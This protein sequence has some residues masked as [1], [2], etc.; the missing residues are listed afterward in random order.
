MNHIQTQSFEIIRS[1]FSKDE[2][3][4][5]REEADHVSRVEGSACVRHLR[6]KS[7]EFDLLAISGRLLD[8]LPEGLSPVRSILFDKTPE[9]NW[10][11]PWHQD[12]TITVEEKVEVAG[13]EP[14]STKDGS[15]HVQPP[16]ALLKEMVTIRIHLDQTT[17]SNGALR[18]IPKSQTNGKIESKEILS[19][20]DES[21]F[22]CECDAGD[23]LLMSPLVLHASMRSEDPKRRRIIHFEY[24][25]LNSLD[26]QLSWHEPSTGT[27]QDRQRL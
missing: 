23:L 24:A 1:V 13:Y 26:K 16:E 6:K 21:E 22:I 5:M 19:Y 20:I 2:I 10:L 14:W 17:K 18:V 12:L 4:A 8:L 3:K 11:V 9:E 25:S 27:R 15:V 7:R